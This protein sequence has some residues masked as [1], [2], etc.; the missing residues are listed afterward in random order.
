MPNLVICLFYGFFSVL[1]NLANKQLMSKFE[2]PASFLLFS[3]ELLILLSYPIF[4]FPISKS[5]LKACL[6][7]SFFFLGN[8]GFSLLGMKYVNLP[9]YVCIRKTTT[10]VIF[11]ITKLEKKKTTFGSFLG[12]FFITLG[13]VVAGFNDLNGD[14]FGY[15]IAFVS[16]F[17]NALQLVCANN[18]SLQGFESFTIFFSVSIVVF[19]ISFV[20]NIRNTDFF[21]VFGKSITN[22]ELLALVVGTGSSVIANFF[23]ILCSTQVSPIATSVT[24]NIKDIFSMII[25]IFAFS[26]VKLSFSFVNGLIFSTVGA[27]IYSYCK[28]YNL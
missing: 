28:V 11:L 9:M 15:F 6:P 26:D 5:S 13:S 24:G 19:P 20:L 18:L 1:N 23:M 3:Q 27:G 25:G 14:F 2:F 21:Q 8:I 4:R 7:L 12:V 22:F 10:L 17:M 16:V